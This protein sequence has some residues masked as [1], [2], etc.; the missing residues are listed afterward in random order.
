MTVEVG[1]DLGFDFGALRRAIEERDATTQL[2]RYTDD[3][4]ARIVDRD[5]PPRTPRVL[6]GKD[7][8]RAWIEDVCARDM[9]HRIDREVLGTG[10]AAFTEACR[11]P[12]GTNVLCSA[13][14]ELRD[15]RIARHLVVQV[16]DD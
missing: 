2:A 1:S 7:A 5:H 9:T 13:V 12:D 3:A 8:I 10:R 16:W 11:Y 15:G 4:E 14:L 6:R